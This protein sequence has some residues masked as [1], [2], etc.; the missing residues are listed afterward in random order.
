MASQEEQVAF[1][2]GAG[3]RF[4]LCDR[5][6]YGSPADLEDARALALL[7]GAGDSSLDGLLFLLPAESGADARLV[8]YNRDGSRPEACGNGLR[9]AAWFMLQTAPDV[10]RRL[11]IETDAGPREVELV[12]CGGR[13]AVLR[14]GMGEAELFDAA[15][16]PLRGARAT[17]VRLGNPHCVL[18][19]Q[20]EREIPVARVG[21]TMQSHPAFADGV[22]VGFLAW[23]EGRWCLRVHERGVGETEACGTGA[24]AA[25]AVIAA[26]GRDDWPIEIRMP[27]GP[28]R[29]DWAPGGGLSLEGEAVLEAVSLQ[30]EQAGPPCE[31]GDAAPAAG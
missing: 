26:H 25:A 20:D 3:N 9:C 5:R 29:I 7:L 28:L 17:G 1:L 15:P 8:I 10:G 24:T 27:G 14:A 31:Q 21:T 22:N 2:T 4:G 19:V 18:E 6:Q 30:P 12:A 16:S 23:R 11:R 13:R